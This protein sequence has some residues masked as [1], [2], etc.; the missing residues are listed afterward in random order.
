[1]IKTNNVFQTKQL[2]CDSALTISQQNSSDFYGN[3]T[4]E[5]KPDHF[6]HAKTKLSK[7]AS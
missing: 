3:Q 2:K 5:C 1:M 7:A 4:L 6:Q